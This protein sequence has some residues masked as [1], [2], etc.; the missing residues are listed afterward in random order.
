MH[1]IA[2][3]TSI[4]GWFTTAPRVRVRQHQVEKMSTL[5]NSSFKYNHIH[6]TY[7]FRHLTSR[8]QVGSPVTMRVVKV[9]EPIMRG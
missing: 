6:K 8:V 1:N 3:I 4:V 7:L 9:P 5:N 2:H